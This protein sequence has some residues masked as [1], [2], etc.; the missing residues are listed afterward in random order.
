VPDWREEEVVNEIVTRERNEQRGRAND[1]HHLLRDRGEYACEC[2]WD[3]CASL[4]YLSRAEYEDVRHDAIHFAIALDH[5]NPE[6]EVVL[7]QNDR[8]AVVEKLLEMPRRLARDT[9]PRS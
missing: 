9:D 3:L 6:F 5:E 2:G 7:T 1:A 8:F 4:I